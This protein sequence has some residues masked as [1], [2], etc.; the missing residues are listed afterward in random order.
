MYD[1]IDSNI[2]VFGTYLV[3]TVK[4]TYEDLVE[5][6]GEPHIQG[7]DKTT[8]EW[9]LLFEDDDGFNY[10]AT[11]YDWKTDSTP[12]GEYNWHVGGY[13]QEAV[14]AVH[15]LMGVSE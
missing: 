11:I 3:G 13:G 14:W 9:S 4:C 6:L 15:D 10:T 12:M 2:P 1:L 7:G 5:T 8:A